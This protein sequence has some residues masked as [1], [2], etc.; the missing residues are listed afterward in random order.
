MLKIQFIF[1]IKLLK[2]YWYGM[3]TAYFCIIVPIYTNIL[4]KKVTIGISTNTYQFMCVGTHT[5]YTTACDSLTDGDLSVDCWQF[6]VQLK[7]LLISRE[8]AYKYFLWIRFIAS[9]LI[10]PIFDKITFGR[11][12]RSEASTKQLMQ[13][14]FVFFQVKSKNFRYAQWQFKAIADSP[15]KCQRPN[16]MLLNYEKKFDKNC[17]YYVIIRVC[18]QQKYK[19]NK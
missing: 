8:K 12:S 6:F 5:R 1:Q 16:V 10:R 7:L 14:I 19:N 18:F 13:S 11:K 17:L 2:V 4:K 15:T 3:I 9:K